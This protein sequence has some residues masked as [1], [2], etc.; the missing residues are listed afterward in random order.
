MR[1][2]LFS[3]PFF[4]LFLFYFLFPLFFSFF[5][6]VF[7]LCSAAKG[8][9]FAYIKM[10][11]KIE[12]EYWRCPICIMPRDSEEWK[13]VGLEEKNEGKGGGV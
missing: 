2:F 13:E 11:M 10:Y 1:S 6:S 5:S 8:P 7:A 4:P 9:T 3:F 12:Y